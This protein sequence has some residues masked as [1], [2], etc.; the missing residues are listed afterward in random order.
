M[1]KVAGFVKNWQSC[2]ERFDLQNLTVMA[3]KLL[4]VE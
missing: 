2:G 3:E 4:L 1:K